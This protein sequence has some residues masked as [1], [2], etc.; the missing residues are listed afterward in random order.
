MGSLAQQLF[1]TQVKYFKDAFLEARKKEHGYLLLDLHHLTP[2]RLR[3]RSTI[4]IPE[5]LEIYATAGGPEDQ[6]FELE[7]A[8]YINFRV[9]ASTFRCMAKSEVVK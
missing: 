7:P 8:G 5:V 4:F 3:V 2:A 9:K 1:P 6:T